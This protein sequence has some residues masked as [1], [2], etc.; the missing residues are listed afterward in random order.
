MF[1]PGGTLVKYLA[2]VAAIMTVAGGVPRVECVC[3]D[4]RV[5]FSCNGSSTPGPTEIRHRRCQTVNVTPTCRTHAGLRSSARPVSDG[6]GPVVTTCGCQRA[7]VAD[8]LAY[9][10]GDADDESRV[11]AGGPVVWMPPVA[12]GQTARFA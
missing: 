3:P 1:P 9:T 2:T 4:G 6:S 5:K 8:L 12:S 11:E 10:A 7:F